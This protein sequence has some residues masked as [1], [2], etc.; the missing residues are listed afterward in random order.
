GQVSQGWHGPYP[1]SSPT[2]APLIVARFAKSQCHPCPAP[3]PVHHLPRKHPHRRL[4]PTRTPR[5][6]T[7]HPCRA[8]D[9]RVENPLR[10]PLRSR[11]NSQRVRPR[12][13][14]ATLPLPRTGKGPHPARPDR[15]RHQHRAPQRPPIDRGSTPATPT[16]RLPDLPR[17][18]Q[19]PPAEVLAHPGHLT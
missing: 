13:R 11:G 14:H 5:P 2:A 4:S 10:G 6:A 15:H 19:D 1:T 17:S 9:T 8:T 12:T 7:P 16:D 3:R 18:A